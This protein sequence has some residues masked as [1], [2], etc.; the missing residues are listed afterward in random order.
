M[1]IREATKEDVPQVVP[2]WRELM[3]FHARRDAYFAT[4]QWAQ[5]AFEKYVLENIEKE[6][7][8]VWVAQSDSAIV[9]Y[10]QSMIVENPPVLHVKRYGNISDLAVL[11]NYR[12]QG[13]GE[14]FVARA[15]EWFR[16]QNLERVEVRVAVTNKISTQFWRKMGF[17]T[18][19]ETMSKPLD[20][21]ERT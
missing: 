17:A 13:I 21:P 20:L 4:C 16:S 8:M 2:V 7:A 14:D 15:M 12:R 11:D 6:D 1:E 3:E 10:C 9:G 19:L 5:E 18:Y